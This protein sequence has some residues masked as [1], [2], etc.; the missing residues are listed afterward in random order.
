M[1]SNDNEIDEVEL[2]RLGIRHVE[3][4]VFQW[5][6][7]LYSNVRDAIVAARKGENDEPSASPQA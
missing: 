3:A 2:A 6:D 5:R 4:N 7:Y 1:T